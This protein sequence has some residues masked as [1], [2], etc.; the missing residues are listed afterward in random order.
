MLLTGNWV[1]LAAAFAGL[2]LC[3]CDAGSQSAGAG[4]SEPPGTPLA[5]S[6]AEG[7]NQLSCSEVNTLNYEIADVGG[8]RDPQSAAAEGLARLVDLL[9]DDKPEMLTGGEEGTRRYGLRRE[10]RLS[11]TVTIVRTQ[12]GGWLVGEVDA[13]VE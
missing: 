8:E 2:V 9:P 3:G 11:A 10:G 6:D 12:D 4:T 13:C 1:R 5:Q 7:N